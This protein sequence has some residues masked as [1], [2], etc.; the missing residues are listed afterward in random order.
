MDKFEGKGCSG[1]DEGSSLQGQKLMQ[2]LFSFV[3][4]SCHPASLAQVGAN[5]VAL[6]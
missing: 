5:S 2:V 1:W 3:E 4:P 6:H